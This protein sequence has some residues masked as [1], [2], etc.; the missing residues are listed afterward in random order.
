MSALYMNCLFIIPECHQLHDHR[1][2]LNARFLY[3]LYVYSN[4]EILFFMQRKIIILFN[5]C[6]PPCNSNHRPACG[7]LVNI[8]GAYKILL[9]NVFC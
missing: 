8:L 3:E 9:S 5:Y 7:L 1:H 2:M 4:I 6:G